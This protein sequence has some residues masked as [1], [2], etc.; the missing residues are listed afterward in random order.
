MKAT[1]RIKRLEQAVLP[2]ENSVRVIF[3]GPDN[4]PFPCRHDRPYTTIPKD[5]TVV[6]LIDDAPR[7]EP[8]P[9]SCE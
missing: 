5:G 4:Q 9:C 2:R 3:C 8:L 7:Q 1:E 6:L